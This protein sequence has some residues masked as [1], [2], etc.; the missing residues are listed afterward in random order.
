MLNPNT[1]VATSAEVAQNFQTS[2]LETRLEHQMWAGNF[3]DK[4]EP[5]P[6]IMNCTE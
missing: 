2:E 5:N 3:P 1:P 4:E 6:Q